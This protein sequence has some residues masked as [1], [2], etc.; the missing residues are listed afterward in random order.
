MPS[1]SNLVAGLLLLA[2]VEAMP[3][4]FITSHKASLTMTATVSEMRT[5]Q[6]SQASKNWKDASWDYGFGADA[7]LDINPHNDPAAKNRFRPNPLKHR[8]PEPTPPPQPPVMP[9]VDSAGK[10]YNNG[11]YYTMA[12][13]KVS[14]SK[15]T[16]AGES[17]QSSHSVSGDL[18]G[19]GMSI[20]KDLLGVA[21]KKLTEYFDLAVQKLHIPPTDLPLP[22]VPDN[23]DMPEVGQLQEMTADLDEITQKAGDDLATAEEEGRQKENEEAFVSN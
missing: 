16:K 18:T 14:D 19:T 5:V 4:F 7:P 11:Q 12:N 9:Y 3:K 20:V 23:T 13:E 1:V 22:D 8:P 2:L 15:D 17:F 10:T 21:R 6:P